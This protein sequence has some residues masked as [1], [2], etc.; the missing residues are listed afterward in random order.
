MKQKNKIWIYPLISLGFALMLATSCIPEEKDEILP[1]Y[2]GKIVGSYNG[3][4]TLVGTGTLPATST[5]TKR[6][7]QVVDLSCKIG[8][9]STNLTGI[10]ISISKGDSISNGDIYNLKYTDSSGSFTGKVEG[11]KLTWT[12]TSGIFKETFYGT[13]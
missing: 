9:E 8:S 2:S 5:L 6:S 4:A 7:E 10:G 12:I 11:N 3:T 13:K 1:D